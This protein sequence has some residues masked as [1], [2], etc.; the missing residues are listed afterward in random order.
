M[1]SRRS[2]A[3]ARLAA[4][5]CLVASSLLFWP[6]VS[7][8]KNAAC[9][10]TDDNSISATVQN[11]DRLQEL[12]PPVPKEDDSAMEEQLKQF[13]ISG[14]DARDPAGAD[15]AAKD[16]DNNPYY[17]LKRS[18]VALKKARDAVGIILVDAK[19]LRNDKY[20]G[21]GFP[22]RFYEH[23]YPDNDAVK[24]DH[25]A[26]ALGPV[27]AMELEIAKF[28]QKDERQTHPILS[29][30]ARGDVTAFSSG[31]SAILGMYMQCK[32]SDLMERQHNAPAASGGTSK[33]QSAT[34]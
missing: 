15:K 20:I 29:S 30:T 1:F 34:H 19:G 2:I 11:L 7:I 6:G 18:R 23:E 5:A 10:F 26:Y 22:H 14:L 33:A 4:L 25:A 27:E 3:I 28:L 32:L 8:A 16:L 13:L 24:L 31:Y 17:F 12:L 21:I 9:N